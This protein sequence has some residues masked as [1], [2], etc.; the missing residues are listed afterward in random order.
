ML[1][2][3]PLQH[4]FWAIRMNNS[5]FLRLAGPI[6]SWAGPRVTGNVVNSKLQPT[7]TGLLG[8]LAG[9]LGA[10]RNQWPR[11]IEN[12]DFAIRED[13][14]G[15]FCNEFQ[16]INPRIDEFRLR[17]DERTFRERQL[18][19]HGMRVTKTN[20]AFT[21]DARDGTSVIR[22]TYLIEAEFLVRVTCPEHQD[23]INSA[24]R[25]PIFTTY[26]GKKAFAPSFPFYL[27][28]GESQLLSRI[29]TYDPLFANPKKQIWT[30]QR[31]P[32]TP[33]SGVGA[34]P[35]T[36]SMVDVV[37]NRDTWL[38]QVSTLLMR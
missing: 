3:T 20:L 2:L 35:P 15:Q 26:L 34:L 24:L 1:S 29:P 28:Y 9:A 16:T 38:T 30:Y 25:N 19:I 31:A 36:S 7:R 6:Q 22:R 21:P 10:S 13:R 23:E 18:S 11:W 37:K 14:R 8:L 32:Y 12:V 4:G 5:S 33:D 27:G 17:A